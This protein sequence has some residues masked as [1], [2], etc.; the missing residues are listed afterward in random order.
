MEKLAILIYPNEILKVKCPEEIFGERTDGLVQALIDTIE[1]EKWLGLAAPQVGAVTRI[2]VCKIGDEY[3]E[4]INPEIEFVDDTD[5]G[6][7]YEGCLS[8]PGFFAWVTRPKTI[9]IE[10]QDRTGDEFFEVYSGIESTEIQHEF[11]HLEGKLFVDRLNRKQR[12]HFKAV[13][14]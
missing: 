6:S 4:F 14:R 2:F 12:R 13:Y 11:D 8:V 3:K 5:L 1:N 10:Y 9:Q 7:F